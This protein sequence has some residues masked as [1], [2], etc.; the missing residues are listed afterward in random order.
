[1]FHEHGYAVVHDAIPEDVRA[2]AERAVWEC[3]SGDPG[4][5]E[6]WYRGSQGHSIWTQLFRHPAL[7]AIRTSPRIFTAFA[8]L[9]NSTDLW[10]TVDYAGFNPP[11]RSG[12][13]FPGPSLHWD[14]SLELPI[15]FGLQGILYLT[16]TAANQGA[17]TCVPG[18]HRKIEDWLRGLSNE[19]DPRR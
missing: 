1:R 10:P 17:F 14:M 2:A 9:W 3:V 19:A 5:P 6:T 12:W 11:E 4:R 8:Q 13:R 18:F 16:D 7:D 15:H